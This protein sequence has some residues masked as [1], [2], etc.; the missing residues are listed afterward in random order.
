MLRLND[1]P[2]REDALMEAL[3]IMTEERI[4]PDPRLWNEWWRREAGSRT[5]IQPLEA[6]STG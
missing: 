3:A 1:T 5:T 4:A 2:D 6:A